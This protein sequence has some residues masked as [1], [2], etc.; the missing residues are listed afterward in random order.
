MRYIFTLAILLALTVIAFSQDSVY[1]KLDALMKA[2]TV[3]DKFSGTVLVAR[4]GKILL[5]KGYGYKN[6][7]ARSLNDTNTLFQIASITKQFT[8]TLILQLVEQG[9]LQ[10]SDKLSRFFPDFPRG[11]SITI[12]HLLTHTSGIDHL[13]TDVSHLRLP[14]RGAAAP[15]SIRN[16]FKEQPLDFLPGTKWS[17]SNA[18]YVLLGLIIEQRTGLTW[19]EAVRKNILVPL[20]M[21]HSGLDFKRLVSADKATGYYADSSEAPT[22]IPPILDSLEPY[23]AGAIYGTA[24]DLYKWHRALQRYA[25]V[26]QPLMERAYTPLLN[27]YGYGWIIDSVYGKRGVSH[28][29]G[30]FGFR[31]NLYRVPADDVCVILLANMETESRDQITRNLLAIVYGQPYQ[32]PVKRTAVILPES[33]LAGYVGTYQLEVNGL[34]IDMVLENGRL[35]GKPQRGPVS[36][37][38][39]LDEMNFYLSDN[40]EFLIRFEKDATGKVIKLWINNGDKQ[41]AA[42]KIK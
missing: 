20:R 3:Q 36:E 21:K 15:D 32:L 40:H 4:E 8:S 26:R 2:Y 35:K 39:A 17:Y 25:L 6:Q 33:V 37:L 10:L 27:H 42:P 7:Q 34:L 5:S 12:E 29:G 38:M 28:S 1:A 14:Y 41:S 30:I 24:T 22:K 11:D 9:R 19:F 13:T 16:R 18:G 23:A 31:S